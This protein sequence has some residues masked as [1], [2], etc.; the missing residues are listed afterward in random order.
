M[1]SRERAARA[2]LGVI[3]AQGLDALSLAL[4]AR[5]LGVKA[6]SLYHHF[7]DK[8]ELLKEAARLILLDVSAPD[9]EG[10]NWQDAFVE[11]SLA[12]RRSILRH[13]HAAPLL[14]QFF[15]RRLL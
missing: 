12:T 11:R 1:I 4:V 10:G 14:L 6:P 15:P 5:H 2:A 13:P 7:R 8:A 9:P 3:D